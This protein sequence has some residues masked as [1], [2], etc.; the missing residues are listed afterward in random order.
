MPTVTLAR[1]GEIAVA[2]LDNPPV[3]ALSAALRA[4]LLQ[5]LTQATA[6]QAVTALVIAAIS[7]VENVLICS[8]VSVAI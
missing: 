4:D 2:T 8:A 6:D 7:A 3:N 5:A 1:Q